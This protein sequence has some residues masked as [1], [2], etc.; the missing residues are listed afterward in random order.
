M[1]DFISPPTAATAPIEAIVEHP[2]AD[3][4]RV[5]TERLAVDPSSPIKRMR[6]Q[7]QDNAELNSMDADPP[8]GPPPDAVFD[9]GIQ[10]D[11]YDMELGGFYDRAASPPPLP[12]KSRKKPV[13]PSVCCFFL[14]FK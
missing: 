11:L 13:K 4:R 8:P 9:P 2:S 3:G 10:D 5:Y 1:A 14:D 6:Q 12:E 7:F